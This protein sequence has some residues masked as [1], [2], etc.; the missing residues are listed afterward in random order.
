[1]FWEVPSFMN[2]CSLYELTYH[3]PDLMQH[4][5][6][7]LDCYCD[8]FSAIFLKWLSTL[9]IKI[10]KADCNHHWGEGGKGGKKGQGGEGEDGGNSGGEIDEVVKGR[11]RSSYLKLHYISFSTGIIKFP[12]RKY[13]NV[14]NGINADWKHGMVCSTVI[15]LFLTTSPQ[16][17]HLLLVIA[18]QTFLLN[19]DCSK[20]ITWL[21]MPQVKMGNI[22]VIFINFQIR[23]VE[24][25]YNLKAQ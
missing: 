4:K 24:K 22:W 5:T 15:K 18:H 7:S 12:E 16:Y 6:L 9:N 23:C 2:A 10:H 11:Q 13:C 8:I 20:C 25:T 17:S 3:F 1:M 21:N 14:H 19:Y